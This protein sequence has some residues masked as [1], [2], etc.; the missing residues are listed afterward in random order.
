MSAIHPGFRMRVLT[1]SAILSYKG[2]FT[3]LEPR[4]YFSMK[5]ITPLIEMAYFAFLGKFILGDEG[6]RYAALGNAVLHVAVNG[7]M[8]VTISVGS[9]RWWGTM[10]ALLVTPANRFFIF[11][12]RAMMHILDGI[13]SVVI[14]LGYATFLFGVDFSRTD[15]TSLTVIIP[16]TAVS[17]IGYGLLMGSYALIT[18]HVG[19]IFNA[20]FFALMLI[21][22]ANFPV[23]QLPIWMQPVSY[24]IPLTYG[25]EATRQ[26]VEG[27]NLGAVAPLLGLQ[28]LTGTVMLAV[29]Y[30]LFTEFEKAARK[31]GAVDVT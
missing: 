29:G 23:T 11:I 5:F 13:L 10:G 8:G 4:V 6:M 17:V 14:A 27:A 25:I 1:Q 16:L 26:A 2:T 7:V 12:G 24:A 9:E 20:A 28:T 30:L 18:R 31:K 15:W 22:G 3:W 19:A 21:S